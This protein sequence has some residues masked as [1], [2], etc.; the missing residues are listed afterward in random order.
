MKEKYI[1][2]GH[3][4]ELFET[5]VDAYSPAQATYIVKKRLKKSGCANY[6]IDGVMTVA[7]EKAIKDKTC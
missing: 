3:K 4:P 5:I 7:E 6:G 1:V 2:Y